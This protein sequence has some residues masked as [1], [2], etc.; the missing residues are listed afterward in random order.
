MSINEFRTHYDKHCP[1]KEKHFY[2]NN[3]KHACRKKNHLYKVFSKKREQKEVK[4]DINY[5]RIN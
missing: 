3:N 5:I 2:I 1:I 4:K